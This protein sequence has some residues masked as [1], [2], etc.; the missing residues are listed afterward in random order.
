MLGSVAQAQEQSRPPKPDRPET[1]RLVWTTLIAIHH[2]N[3]TGNYSVLRDLSAPSF[4]ERNNPAD[5]AGIFSSVRKADLGLGRAVLYAPEYRSPPE[6]RDDGRLVI[7]GLIPMRPEG[8][9]FTIF[10]Q[11]VR[12]EWRFSSIQI[13]L[14]EPEAIEGEDGP[15]PKPGTSE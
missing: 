11:P 1:A 4:Q 14:E 9:L 7:N 5:L 12:G 2:A 6:I 15:Q 3:V 13:A 10:F 8:I